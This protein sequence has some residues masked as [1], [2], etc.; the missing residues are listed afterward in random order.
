MKMPS[1][2]SSYHCG[3]GRAFSDFRLPSY[4]IAHPRYFLHSVVCDGSL[5]LF[6][7][8]LDA[9]T[10]D[11]TGAQLDRIRLHSEADARRC[12]G[13]DDVAWLQAHEPGDV[14]D[15]LGDAENHGARVAVLTAHAIDLEPDIERLR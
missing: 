8:T 12:S 6:A 2:A 5:C 14:A 9:E 15:D 7:Q 13:G 11:L 10:H 3:S 4:R 1:F